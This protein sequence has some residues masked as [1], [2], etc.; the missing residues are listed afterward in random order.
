MSTKTLFASG[1]LGAGL[2]CTVVS[3]APDAH[4]AEPWP[5]ARP[6]TLV[7]PSAAGGGTDTMGRYVGERLSKVIGQ[8]V[9]IENKPGANGMIGNDTVARARPDGYTLGFTYAATVVSNKL[10]MPQMPHDPQKDLT[11]IAQVGGGGNFLV[12]SKAFPGRTFEEFVKH[13]KANPDVYSYG[14]WGNG[15]GGHIAMEAIKLQTGLQ[16][17]HVPYKG[18][19]PTLVDL[20]GGRIQVAFVDTSSSLAMIQSGEIIPIASSGR[21]RSPQ[22]PDVP[23]LNELGV[24]YDAEAWYGVLGPKDMAPELVQQINAAINQVLLDPQVRERFLQLNMADPPA[25]SPQDF[26]D[27]IANDLEVWGEVIKAAN[28]T[29]Q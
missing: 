6:V 7:I 27:T 29:I 8:T 1:L 15:S 10:L 3:G 16:L 25:R 19:Q 4:A 13:V 28:I 20:V 14:S 17:Q 11:P 9:V 26:A 2:L 5:K 24:K 22:N 12:V 21:K 18:V 23:T